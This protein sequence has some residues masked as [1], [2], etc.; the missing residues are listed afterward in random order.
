M[1][2]TGEIVNRVAKSPLI[3]LDLQE[4]YPAGERKV[5]DIK[6]WLFQGM[7]L[8]EK[9]FRAT[10]KDHDWSQ[11][12]NCYVAIT[13]SAEAIVPTWAYMLVASKLEGVA[14]L[15]IFGSEQELEKIILKESLSQID[16]EKYQDKKLVIKGCGDPRITEFAYVEIVR[17]LKPVA[18]SIMYGEPCSTVPIYKKP[19][20]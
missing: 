15:M 18:S 16:P 10:V 13:C 2:D 9:E 1:S 3:T 5:L 6:D 4:Y 11:Y 14:K 20:K 8:K 17:I 19:R 12:E 7:I